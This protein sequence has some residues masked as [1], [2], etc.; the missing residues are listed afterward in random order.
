MSDE[1]REFFGQEGALVGPK[2]PSAYAKWRAERDKAIA[3]PK[4]NEAA[5]ELAQRQTLAP[6][7]PR[8]KKRVVRP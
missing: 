5:L 6:V 3:S 7:N 8:S 2:D 4:R 1:P